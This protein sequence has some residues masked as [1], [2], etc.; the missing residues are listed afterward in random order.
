MSYSSSSGRA[1]TNSWS[2]LWDDVTVEVGPSTG[3]RHHL[4]SL[5]RTF[6]FALSTL[7]LVGCQTPSR[8]KEPDL[9]SR[10]SHPPLTTQEIDA[11]IGSKLGL[12]KSCF[13]SL[14]KGTSGPQGVLSKS[15][16]VSG[17]GQVKEVRTQTSDFDAKVTAE[18]G[19]CLDP[20]ILALPFPATRGNRAL[21]ITY[22][23]TVK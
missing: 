9:E 5:Y 13:A 15:W 8:E 22:P 7:L 12:M 19:L 1:A 6:N 16:I 20:M 11:V 14:L 18:L 23:F 3:A 4:T 10:P 2:F 21:R 17:D